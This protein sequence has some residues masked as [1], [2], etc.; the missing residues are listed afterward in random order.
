MKR[1]L[2]WIAGLFGLFVVASVGLG[3]VMAATHSTPAA[4]APTRATQSAQQT[5]QNQLKRDDQIARCMGAN[6]DVLP[7]R[8]YAAMRQECE[9]HVAGSTSDEGA[10]EAYQKAQDADL[11]AKAAMVQS[12]GD[13]GH[14]SDP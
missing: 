3:I 6:A 7:S 13:P 14:L 8:V 11:D 9:R 5:S 2:N 10:A 12:R 4:P 1:L